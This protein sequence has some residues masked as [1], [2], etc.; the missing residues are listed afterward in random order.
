MTTLP[1]LGILGGGQL[2]QMIALAALP[3][4]VRCHVYDPDPHAPARL[5]AL[6]HCASYDDE[7][8]LRAFAAAVDVITYEFENVP[9]DCVTTVAALRPLAPGIEALRVCQDRIYEKS[10]ART[11]G[12]ATAPFVDLTPDVPSHDALAA[13][14]GHA[15]V[16]TRRLGY[17]GKGQ[18]RVSTLAELDAARHDFAG[19]AL[20]LE[21]FVPFSHEVSIIAARGH[22]GTIV[23]Y[24]LIENIHHEGIL[25]RSLA[26]AP[27]ADAALETRA[28]EIADAVLTAFGYVGVLTIECFVVPGPA[29]A[30]LVINEF[31]PRVHNSGHWSIEGADVS[32]FALHVAAV[33]GFPL[34]RPT[35]AAA[36]GMLNLIGAEPLPRDIPPGVAIHR[37]H[38]APRPGRKVG[39][40][41]AVASDRGALAQTLAQCSALV[42]TWHGTE[43]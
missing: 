31:A 6:H 38:K 35:V 7:S 11:L 10:F 28:T 32:Q 9:T 15:I 22:D 26:P 40:L 19:H 24:P 17:D 5:C 25:R 37:Y 33:C 42:G 34:Q 8:A 30:S 16:K 2:A 14:G 20:I 36:A 43:E 1:V 21:G 29:G 18:R 3:L 39:H 41:T 27:V 12:L 4:G 23:R 13:V